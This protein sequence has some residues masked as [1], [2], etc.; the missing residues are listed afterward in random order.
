VQNNF[1]ELYE[2]LEEFKEKIEL[3][4]EEP[5][6]PLNPP[7]LRGE[8]D[9]SFIRQESF[10]S[11]LPLLRREIDQSFT[12]HLLRKEKQVK[13]SLING[14]KQSKSPLY[15]GGLRGVYTKKFLLIQG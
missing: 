11:I 8:I 9:Q 3:L 1:Y 7:L 6:T 15:K 14:E 4:G 2:E 5:Q 10:D 13:L 12:S